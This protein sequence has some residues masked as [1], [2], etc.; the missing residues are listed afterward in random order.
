MATT[1]FDDWEGEYLAHFR[2]KGSKNGVRRY[3]QEDGTWTPLGLRERKARELPG[4]RQ[5]LKQ[6]NR[7]GSPIPKA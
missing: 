6:R 2:T 5:L 7:E 4:P 1:R 3:Q